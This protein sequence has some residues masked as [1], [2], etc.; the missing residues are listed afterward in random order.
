M[1]AVDAAKKKVT[2][3]LLEKALRNLKL[4]FRC[5]YFSF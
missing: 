4:V 3:A 2:H 1:H 5:S